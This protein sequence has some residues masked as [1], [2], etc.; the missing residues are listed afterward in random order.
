MKNQAFL[1][2]E[3]SSLRSLLR[4]LILDTAP[5]HELAEFIALHEPGLYEV[6]KSHEALLADNVG[7]GSPWPEDEMPL[8]PGPPPPAPFCFSCRERSGYLS[9][10]WHLWRRHHPLCLFGTTHFLHQQE[11]KTELSEKW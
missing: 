8:C 1:G 9:H 2:R 6:D 7:G 11:E 5:F 3:S 4:G 10:Q